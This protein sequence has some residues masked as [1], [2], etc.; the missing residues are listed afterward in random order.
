M[1]DQD[2]LRQIEACTLPKAEFTHRNHLRLAW[3]YL[4]D[5]RGGDPDT[6]VADTIQ[7]YAT[8]LGATKK[9][10]HALT[11]AWMRRVEAAMAQTPGVTF[12][13]LIEIHPAL[14]TSTLPAPRAVS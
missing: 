6:R 4:S 1:T 11:F 12:D 2:F 9:Y 13:A 14:L 10:N 8:S 5:P 7:R 3:L